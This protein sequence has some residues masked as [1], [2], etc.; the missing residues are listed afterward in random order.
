MMIVDILH[1]FAVFRMGLEDRLALCCVLPD[2]SGFQP[3][4]TGAKSGLLERWMMLIFV[5]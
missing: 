2:E 3:L 4:K 1:L 5:P